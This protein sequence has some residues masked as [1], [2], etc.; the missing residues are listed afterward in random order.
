MIQFTC[1]NCNSKLNAKDELAGQVRKCPR[2]GTAVRIEPM[3]TPAPPIAPPAQ[4]ENDGLSDPV[5]AHASPPGETPLPHPVPERLDRHG[6]YLIL[7]PGHV[8]AI[9]E[10][11]GRG[12]QLKTSGGLVSATRNRDK[13]PTEGDFRLVELKLA[14]SE[15]GHRM[16]R[17]VVFGLARRH[18]LLNLARGDDAILSAV[19]GPKG[20]NRDQ[21]N[22]VRAA[23]R[24]RFMREVWQGAER[25]LEYLGNADFHSPG[26]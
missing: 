3:E 5:A 19:T 6:H 21:K 7:G 8:I 17:I 2:C 4:E 23:I 26:A 18:A 14:T 11:N 13:L 16:E 25:V 20:L 24:D 12:W 15:E 10:S 1:P 22:L 9:W